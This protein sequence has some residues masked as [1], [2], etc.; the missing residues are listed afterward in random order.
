LIAV[1]FPQDRFSR[2]ASFFPY[3]TLFR[4]AIAAFASVAAWGALLAMPR[5]I[6]AK[7]VPVRLSDQEFWKTVMTFSEPGGAFRSSGAVRSEDRKS[8]RLNSSH[9]QI[10]Y[11]VLCLK[12]KI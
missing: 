4:S 2:A 10:S 6:A 8:T 7:T 3:T 12:K 11:A 1:F 5:D 9:D